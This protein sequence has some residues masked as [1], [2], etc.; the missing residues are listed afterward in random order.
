M[1]KNLTKDKLDIDNLNKLKSKTEKD[2]EEQKKSDQSKI[3]K[4]VK[5]AKVN[6]ENKMNEGK[7]ALE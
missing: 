4:I 7:I 5:D 3:E 1:T 2:L 6:L